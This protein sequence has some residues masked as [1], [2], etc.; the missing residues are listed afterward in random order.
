METWV[1]LFRGINVGGKNVLPMADLRASLDSLNLKN[2][3]TYIQSGNVVFESPAKK[4]DSLAKKIAAMV[5]R[6]FGFA[7]RVLVIG[8]ESLEIA[9]TSN[10]FPESAD[11]PK[12]LHLFFLSE[13]ST[14]P[15]VAKID[16]VKAPSEQYRLTDRVFY[17]YAPDGIGRSKLAANVESYLGVTATARNLRTVTKVASMCET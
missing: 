12:S 5:E 16:D 3:R 14:S 9:L 15:Q 13:P 8:E 11:D 7:A 1:A 4:A 2:V 10:P 17:L 6:E